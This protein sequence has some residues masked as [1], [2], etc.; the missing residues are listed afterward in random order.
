[1]KNKRKYQ[2]KLTLQEGVEFG[3]LIS[4]SLGKKPVQ[5]KVKVKKKATKKKKPKK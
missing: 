1:M 3:D 5:P 4:L 2:P